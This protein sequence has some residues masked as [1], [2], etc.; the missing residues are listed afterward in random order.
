MSWFA[1]SGRRGRHHAA[2]RRFVWTVCLDG[3][4]CLWIAWSFCLFL[5]SFV[6]ELPELFLAFGYRSRTSLPTSKSRAVSCRPPAS[7]EAYQFP[8]LDGADIAHASRRGKRMISFDFA[9][10]RARSARRRP[11]LG[12]CLAASA[13]PTPARWPDM[14]R[15]P[16]AAPGSRPGW[17]WVASIA[18]LMACGDVLGNRRAPLIVSW[19]VMKP[20][21]AET[22][23]SLAR[24]RRRPLWPCPRRRCPARMREERR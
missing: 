12:A 4:L 21:L 1:V 14:L 10:A 16:T 17:R 3:W 22:S 18:R 11:R 19:V 13:A 6:E 8:P 15:L 2:G 24:S 5:G 23:W 9:S 7:W 20:F